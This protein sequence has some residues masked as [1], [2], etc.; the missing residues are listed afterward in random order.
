[1]EDIFL[2]YQNKKITGDS[3]LQ[4]EYS[5]RTETKKEWVECEDITIHQLINR[6]LDEFEDAGFDLEMLP[7]ENVLERFLTYKPVINVPSEYTQLQ[8]AKILIENQIASIEVNEHTI[9]MVQQMKG[10]LGT[11]LSAIK[12]Y[13]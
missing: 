4:E 5:R 3:T 7:M 12:G 11:V 1:M 13:K 9:D 2:D 6:I 10:T 8:N